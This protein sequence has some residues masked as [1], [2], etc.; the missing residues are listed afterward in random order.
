MVLLSILAASICTNLTPATSASCAQSASASDCPPLLPVTPSLPQRSPERS[1]LLSGDALDGSACG[2]SS[3]TP[4]LGPCLRQGLDAEV[5]EAQRCVNAGSAA[6]A[7]PSLHVSEVQLSSGDDGHGVVHAGAWCGLPCSVRRVLLPGGCA[8]GASGQRVLRGLQV[9]S[10]LPSHPHL[11]ATWHVAVRP[12][13][14]LASAAA[15][16]ASASMV[17]AAHGAGGG[18]VGGPACADAP[19]SAETAAPSSGAA[20]YELVLVQVRRC[21]LGLPL[22]GL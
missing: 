18:S 6:A 20:A 10:A 3:Q 5:R 19:Q 11:V 7:T 4:P 16:D 13:G 14:V 17:C 22:S 21:A 15:P 12:L 2:P 9:S 8:L 1:F